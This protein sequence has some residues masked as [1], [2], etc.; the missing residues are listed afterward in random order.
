MKKKSFFVRGNLYIFQQFSIVI[1][2]LSLAILFLNS[3]MSFEYVSGNQ[4]YSDIYFINP[5]KSSGDFADS[6]VFN[7]LLERS[8]DDV[9]RYTAIK[10]QMEEKGN[11]DGNKVIDVTGYS[12]R[13]DGNA[14]HTI[15][16][17]PLEYSLS[18]LIKW[19]KYENQGTDN[20]EEANFN[21]VWEA[22][23]FFDENVLDKYMYV[24]ELF[25]NR[26]FHLGFDGTLYYYVNDFGNYI[27]VY[28]GA[29]EGC[30]AVTY[31]TDTL[32][33]SYTVTPQASAEMPSVMDTVVSTAYFYEIS[34]VSNSYTSVLKNREDIPRVV[35]HLLKER[36]Q[37]VGKKNIIDIADSWEEYFA[38][39]DCLQKSIEKLSYNYI[40]YISYKKE[41]RN[42][43]L[44]FCLSMTV[45][46]QRKFY[47]NDLKYPEGPISNI[48]DY[49]INNFNKYII[50]SPGDMIF[51]TN[52]KINEKSVFDEMNEDSFAYP[53]KTNMWVGI[54]T[55]DFS[56]W[57]KF[58][59][60]ASIYDGFVSKAWVYLAVAALGIA[61]W[62]VTC[63]FLCRETGKREDS[64]GKT[65]HHI[66]WF[67]KMPTEVEILSACIIGNFLYYALNRNF[68]YVQENF[69][70][71]IE[72]GE[73]WIYADVGILVLLVSVFIMTFFYSF[74]RRFRAG[75]VWSGSITRFLVIKIRNFSVFVY[76][77]GKFVTRIIL[78]C[79]ILIVL[80]LIAGMLFY[81]YLDAG[82]NRKGPFLYFNWLHILLIVLFLLAVLAADLGLIIL[83]LWNQRQ[84][85]RIL[86]GIHRI[87]EGDLNYQID[88]KNMH[89]GNRVL[90]EAVNHI[91]ES[92][93]NA[94]ETSMKDEKLKAD[95]ITNVSHDIKTP[96]TS[97]INYVDLMKREK[98]ETEPLKGYIGVL[99]EKSQR[100]KQL[101]EDL[102]EASKI[103]SGNIQLI[104]NRINL[105]ELLNQAMGEFEERFLEKG[106]TMVKGFENTPVCIMA[107]NRRIWR[108]VENLLSN[109]YKYAM[110]G[111]RTYLDMKTENG[112]VTVSVKNIS[113]QPLNIPADELTERFIRGDVSRSTEGSGLGLSIAKSLT[114]AQGGE[115]N[116]YL[117]GDLFKVTLTFPV[118]LPEKRTEEE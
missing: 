73:N 92:I 1:A 94:V 105:T 112:K 51:R 64:E 107:D 114:V 10:S 78:P 81:R 14:D 34:G 27:P 33:R 4:V 19:G 100:L 7:Q 102:V 36:Y 26:D 3:F 22:V 113:A 59:E 41:Y 67:D 110:E 69:K 2:V 50:Y 82:L 62:C 74:I 109:V 84:R 31:E 103:S 86:S 97:I 49:Y 89:G 54:N 52:T 80:N 85:N 30:D 58:S 56:S 91:S 25:Q 45:D 90:A 111:T 99:D 38:Y 20:F 75:N 108:V 6:D 72:A 61:G 18:D 71:I 96:L 21:S 40:Q 29:A 48:D 12:D 65:V 46:G 87:S 115:F 101:T 9:V 118:V 70:D 55:H 57:D 32:Q 117:D 88:V 53:E 43:N 83:I 44:K 79:S 104:M 35:V 106:I 11:F 68:V 63:F 95:L 42:S 76:D 39:C 13:P 66:Y 28:K 24:T 93:R 15:L 98:I 37:T 16:R 5:F 8:V 47:G 77:N 60:A 17:E 116:I 23:S